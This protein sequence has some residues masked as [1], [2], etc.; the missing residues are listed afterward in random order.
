MPG[1]SRMAAP[2]IDGHGSARAHEPVVFPVDSYLC[3][4]TDATNDHH[5]QWWRWMILG[6]VVG[7]IAGFAL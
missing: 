2:T 7:F 4:Y 5:G 3:G 1:R 6:A